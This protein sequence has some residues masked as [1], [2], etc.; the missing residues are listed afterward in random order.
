VPKI[1][2]I[3]SPTG[4]S[5]RP[6]TTIGAALAAG[7]NA[8][9]GGTEAAAVAGAI[10]FTGVANTAIAVTV[11]AANTIADTGVTVTDTT[12]S[13]FDSLAFVKADDSIVVAGTLTGTTAAAGASTNT[14]AVAATSVVVS[15]GGKV[16]FAAAD[17]TLAEK[18]LA[19]AADDTN[20]AD[21]EVAFFEHGGNTYVYFAN[22]TSDATTDAL[23]QLTGLV[24]LTTLSITTGAITFV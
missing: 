20:L 9:S 3:R 18:V 5:N 21:G 12:V 22:D 6:L 16:T 15:A 13:G 8:A 10:T 7:Y 23:I 11:T 1:A 17:D 24:D 19:I 14:T 2:E 4:T